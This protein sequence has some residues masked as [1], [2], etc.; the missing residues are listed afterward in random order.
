VQHNEF[1]FTLTRRCPVSRDKCDGHGKR[2][3][4]KQAT[5]H[6]ENVDT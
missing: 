2:C 3:R 1:D 4:L 5:E 6:A